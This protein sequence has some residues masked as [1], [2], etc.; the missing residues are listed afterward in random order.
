MQPGALRRIEINYN[1][2]SSIF[3]L[4]APTRTRTWNPL[5]KSRALIDQIVDNDAVFFERVVIDRHE[6]S[7]GY[8]RRAVR[9]VVIDG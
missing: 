9:K 7:G 4:R 1:P 2:Q 5:M 3:N 6:C 8:P